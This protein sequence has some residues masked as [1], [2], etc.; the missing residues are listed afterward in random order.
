MKILNP[1]LQFSP[2]EHLNL[3][4]LGTEYIFHLSKIFQKTN[5]IP[6]KASKLTL[7]NNLH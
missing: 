3:L 5:R 1:I 6:F 7:L 4:T 2:L